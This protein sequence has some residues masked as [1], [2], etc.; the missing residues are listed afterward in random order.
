MKTFRG[1]AHVVQLLETTADQDPLKKENVPDATKLPANRWIYTMASPGGPMEWLENGTLA[2]FMERAQK[3]GHPLPNR[4]LWRL[5]MCL[6]RMCIAFAW[7]DAHDESK[8]E[9]EDPR[10]EVPRSICYNPDI[11]SGNLVFGPFVPDDINL[12]HRLTPVLKMIDLGLVERRDTPHKK[13]WSKLVSMSIRLIGEQMFM[14]NGVGRGAD[15]DPTL[16]SDLEKI[17]S[18]C[19]SSSEDDRPQLLELAIWVSNAVK[20]RD[21]AWY[22]EQMPGPANDGEED[23]SILNLVHELIINANTA[24]E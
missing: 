12:E 6:V 10:D 18:W 7:P 8:V 3:K 23:E 19:M 17:V 20:G 21:A 16:D 22:R 11:G 2:G 14:I 24:P 4:I 13:A 5:F 9:L 1:A 15:P